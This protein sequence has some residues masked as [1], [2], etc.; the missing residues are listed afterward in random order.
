MKNRVSKFRIIGDGMKGAE[1]SYDRKVNH[2]KYNTII[3]PSVSIFPLPVPRSVRTLLGS[4]KFFI[5]DMMGL[6]DVDW[7]V[8][9]QEGFG[10]IKTLDDDASDKDMI[11][12]AQMCKRYDAVGV[13]SVY[14]D[15]KK[16]RVVLSGSITSGQTVTSL[17]NRDALS[18]DGYYHWSQ[19]KELVDL[20]FKQ[21]W[22][23]VDMTDDIDPETTNDYIQMSMKK[24]DFE[25]EFA[26]MTE[27]DRDDFMIQELSSRGAIV[28]REGDEEVPSEIEDDFDVDVPEVKE[29]E[30]P[31]TDKKVSVVEEAPSEIEDESEKPE[32]EMK[33]V[34]DGNDE[35]GFGDD[36]DDF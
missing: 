28:M 25:E 24:K 22:G 8:F 19:L 13:T 17:S 34:E 16:E 27:K 30:K 20:L 14:Y 11:L 5:L 36:E 6:W 18:M 29:P 4:F 32:P 2:R 3:E 9:L 10:G 23:L 26:G 12:Y 21:A 7:N 15:N 35:G 33:V 31:H 1:I